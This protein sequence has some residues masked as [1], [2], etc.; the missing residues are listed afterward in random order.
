[1]T[2]TQEGYRPRLVD[3]QL[4]RILGVAGAVSLDGPKWCGKTWT[5]LNHG[6][7]AFYVADP[8]GGFRNRE[9]AHLDPTVALGGTRPHV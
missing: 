6:E 3:R 7:S 9:L 2:L 5:A 4:A 1:M 8:A